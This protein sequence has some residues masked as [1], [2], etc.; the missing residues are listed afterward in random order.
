MAQS[1]NSLVDTMESS[2]AA[3]TEPTADIE[4]SDSK[5]KGF[6]GRLQASRSFAKK[7][8]LLA[9]QMEPLIRDYLADVF[10]VDCSTRLILQLLKE[11]GEVESAKPFLKAVL[12]MA[13][14]SRSGIAGTPELADSL[15]DN[16]KFS[17]DLRAPSARV[18]K[19]FRQMADAQSV[20]QDWIVQIMELA[21]ELASSDDAQPTGTKPEV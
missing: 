13:S 15:L 7:M 14:A 9:N 17:K 2:N 8:D 20:F 6:A 18:E 21:P 16:A 12:G 5:G 11:S 4:R 1:V 10:V 3:A 19:G